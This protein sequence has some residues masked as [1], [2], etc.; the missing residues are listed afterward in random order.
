ML[1]KQQLNKLYQYSYSLTTNSD[2]AYDLLQTGLEKYLRKNTNNITNEMAYIRQ[3]IR[4][5][6]IDQQRRKKC[7]T[8]E[9]IEADKYQ[10][11]LAIDTSSLEQI[12]IVEEQAKMV[13]ELLSTSER[14]IIYLWAIEG[15][16]AKQ[17]SDETRVP[18]GT[19]LS[20]IHRLKHRIGNQF[21][22]LKGDE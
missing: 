14:E 21:K 15:Y 4:N 9:S 5:Q 12:V 18:R 7:I 8:F 19:I 20:R 13:W 11:T 1:N 10:T 6:F 2:D 22:Q 3:I 16:T 17:I